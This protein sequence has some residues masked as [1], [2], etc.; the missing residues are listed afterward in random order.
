MR[1]GR[2]KKV[3][4]WGRVEK[5]KITKYC[6]DFFFFKIQLFRIWNN[7]FNRFRR[8]LPPSASASDGD[9]DDGN[10]S[11][12]SKYGRTAVRFVRAS[13][14]ISLLARLVDSR[15]ARNTRR[16]WRHASSVFASEAFKRYRRRRRKYRRQYRP[17]STNTEKRSLGVR[18]VGRASRKTVGK[19]WDEPPSRNGRRRRSFECFRN[20]QRGQKTRGLFETGVW[21]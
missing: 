4:G 17:R 2:G 10:N 19:V 20:A 6:W 15:G 3:L 1:G 14:E 21:R 8:G 11:K 9:D 18:T 7:R 16:T 12:N 13:F 5:I